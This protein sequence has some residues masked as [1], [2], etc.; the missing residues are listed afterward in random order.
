MALLAE[1][2]GAA[3]HMRARIE[4]AVTDLFLPD[5]GRLTDQY[6]AAMVRLRARLVGGVEADLRQRLYA[7]GEPALTAALDAGPGRTALARLLRAGVLRDEG[8]TALLLRRAEEYR[9]AGAL[10]VQAAR[11]KQTDPAPA[12]PVLESLPSPLDEMAMSFLAAEARRRDAFHDPAP[13]ES[14]LPAELYHRLVWWA[15]AALRDDLTQ[16]GVAPAAVDRALAAAGGELLA[17][18]DEGDTPEGRAMRLA[19]VLHAAGLLEDQTVVRL[20]AEGRLTLAAAALATRAGI[21]FAPAWEMMA[22]TGGA[23]L[24]LLLRAIGMARAPAADFAFRL[25]SVQEED[26]GAALADRIEAFAALD[27]QR[28]EEALLPWRLDDGYRRALADLAGRGP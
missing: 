4:G 14:E 27:P 28:A 25:A 3:G 17:A 24:L 19:R 22:D 13:G 10:D 8:F 16:Q 20:L 5:E 18:Y 6:R 26:G 1:A 12:P 11:A 21:A 2:A 7:R 23:R 9:L 15:A